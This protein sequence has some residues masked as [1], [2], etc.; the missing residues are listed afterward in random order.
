MA[1]LGSMRGDTVTTHG[2]AGPQQHPRLTKAMGQTLLR[3]ATHVRNNGDGAT[4]GL[5]PKALAAPAARAAQSAIVGLLHKGLA[6]LK[7]VG[8]VGCEL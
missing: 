2:A 6:W 1:A 3:G 8:C 4:R 5:L 7:Q